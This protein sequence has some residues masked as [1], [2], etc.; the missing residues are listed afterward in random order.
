MNYELLRS[1]A[2]FVVP[3]LPEAADEGFAEELIETDATFCA[4]ADGILA[5]VPAMVVEAR[6]CPQLLLADRVEVATDGSLSQETAMRSSESAVAAANDA[7]DQ[8]ALGVGI[9]NALFV[10]DRLCTS[11]KLRPQSIELCL[12]VC[13]FIHCDRR[14]GITFLTTSPVTAVNIAA[15]ILRQDVRMENDIAYL[16]EITKRLVFGHAG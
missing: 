2:E 13:Y 10:D 4:Q 15:E 1:Y 14:S 11:R 7:R 9:G 6:Q 12:N 8:F 3:F 16:D 5:D